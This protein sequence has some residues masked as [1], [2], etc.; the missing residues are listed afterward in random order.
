MAWDPS[1]PVPWQRLTREWLLYVGLM[2]VI[3]LVFFRPDSPTG[4]V[5]GLLVS[6]PM[7]LAFGYVLAKFGYQR[8]TFKQLRAEGSTGG[9]RS[10]S[11]RD[12]DEW[13]P[14][15]KPPPT[16]RTGGGAARPGGSRKK[17]R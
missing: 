14:R 4:V 12:D 9:P 16:R 1:R 6:G 8:K 17:R 15:P 7:Y 13:A 10:R 11:S 3:F 2:G 5:A